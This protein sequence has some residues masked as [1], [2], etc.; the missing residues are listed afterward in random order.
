MD[1]RIHLFVSRV[2]A[3]IREQIMIEQLFRCTGWGLLFAVVIVLF[4]LAI[5]FFYATLVATTAVLLSFLWGIV[6]GIRKT[7]SHMEAALQADAKGYREKLSTAYDLQGKTDPFSLLQKKDAVKIM[8]TF[9]IRKAFP[10]KIRAR[11]VIP[12][13]L[14]AVLFVVCG[15]IDTPAKHVAKTRNAVHKEVKEEIVRLEKV[16]KGL[17][18]TKDIT[19]DELKEVQ[20]QIE[21]DIIS[22]KK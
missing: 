17:R 9:Q 20:E 3:R 4:S 14:F 5:P 11:Q 10:L 22:Y 15:M 12:V 13:L 18:E 8:N 16:E 21:N 1:N 6:E 19:K 7:P 2:R